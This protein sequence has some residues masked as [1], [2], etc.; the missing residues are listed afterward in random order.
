LTTIILVRHGNTDWNVQE[1][2]RGRADVELNETGIKQADLLAEYLEPVAMEAVYSSPLKR[3]FRTAEIVA[4]PHQIDVLPCQELIDFDYGEWQGLSNDTVRKKYGALHTDWLNNPHLARLPQ[5]ESLGDVTKRAIRLVDQVI[6]KH[7]GTVLLVSH[8]V[9]HKVLICA[10]LG[11]DNSHFWNIRLDTCGITSFLY[12]KSRF[13]LVR[14]N[15]TSF[16]KPLGQTSL[17]DF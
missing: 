16:L 7:K 12:E 5:G 9:I 11:L 3:A 4:A 13:V 1:I 2:F 8:R 15:D 10:L 14:H 17:G 6:T